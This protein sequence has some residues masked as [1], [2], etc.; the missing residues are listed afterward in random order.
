ME[1]RHLDTF[2]TEGTFTI[3][4]VKKPYIK[5]ESL[6]LHDNILNHTHNRH[7]STVEIRLCDNGVARIWIYF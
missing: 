1:E 4:I 5:T 7:G 6:L 2:R 3:K